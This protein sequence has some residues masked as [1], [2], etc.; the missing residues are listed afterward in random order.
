MPLRKVK[1]YNYQTHETK[2][3]PIFSVLNKED[4]YLFFVPG[5]SIVENMIPANWIIDSVTYYPDDKSLTYFC[6]GGE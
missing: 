4:F 6:L 3:P 1:F 5:S 2:Y